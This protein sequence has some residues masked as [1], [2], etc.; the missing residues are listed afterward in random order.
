[1]WFRVSSGFTFTECVPYSE[2]ACEDIGVREGWTFKTGDYGAKGC[3][4]YINGRYPGEIFYGRGGTDDQNVMDLD[5]AAVKRPQGYDCD[6]PGST[7]LVYQFTSSHFNNII[8]LK[9]GY[10]YAM[11]FCIF[12]QDTQLSL[13]DDICKTSSGGMK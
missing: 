3:Y 10:N 8:C 5:S 2:Q 4:V 1:M 9:F 12:F 13:A 7:I 11:F 6:I